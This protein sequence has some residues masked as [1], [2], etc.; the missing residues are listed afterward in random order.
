MLD[1]QTT[2]LLIGI[3][4]LTVFLGFH[5]AV[6]MGMASVIGLLVATD[7]WELTRFFIGSTAYE[8]LRDYVFAIVPLFMLMGE[9]IARSGAATDVYVVIDRS[10]T[11]L[12]GRHAH[13]T[14]LGNA[15]FAF[16]TGTSF[17]SAT[18]FARIAYPEMI[19]YRYSKTFALGS[20]AGSACLGMLIPPSLFM[21]VW[22]IL[23]DQSIGILF[24][25]GVLPGLT[26][27]GMMLVYIFFVGITQPTVVGHYADT[28]ERASAQVDEARPAQR[29]GL[30]EWVSF[31]GLSAI[32]VVVLGGIWTGFYTP[33]EGAGIGAVAGLALG[34]VKGM[35]LREVYETVLAVARTSVP[36][37]T[38]LFV[39][40]LYSRTLAFAGVGA[41]IQD[42]FLNTGLDPLGIF[43]IMVLIW[44]IMGMLID[45]V[46][47][48]LLTVPIFGPLAVSL[49]YDPVAFAIMGIVT[50]EAGILTPPFGLLVYAVRA[51]VNEPDVTLNQIFLGST[52][53]WI[54]LLLV[55]VL[56]YIWPGFATWLPSLL[57]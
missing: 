6:A 14:V 36:F 41:G 24:I 34:L 31:V 16:V 9:F 46:S 50:I 35:R 32:I 27:A 8:A 51:V 57:I 25:A 43:V 42:M 17:A 4:L 21:V 33:T 30:R 10:L 47:I 37:M 52:P 56:V 5:V 3:L 18:A 49:G 13:A 26:L 29:A 2:L 44:F 23:T 55:V 53:Y 54:M 40:Q 28:N 39:A 19:R 45:S 11:R 38:L 12:R 48:M 15:I 1:V 22:G 20:I 7:S